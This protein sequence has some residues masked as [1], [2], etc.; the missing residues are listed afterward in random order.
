VSLAQNDKGNN[1]DIF[2]TDTST[3]SRE[4]Q[5]LSFE[6]IGLEKVQINFANP[7]HRSTYGIELLTCSGDFSEA[8]FLAKLEGDVLT[9]IEQGEKILVR[10]K[11]VHLN[12]EIEVNQTKEL[13][14]FKKT[15]LGIEDLAFELDGQWSIGEENSGKL[16][17]ETKDAAIKKLLSLLPG[18]IK[19]QLEEYGSS[20]EL[21]LSGLLNQDAKGNISFKAD[22]GVENGSLF[23]KEFGEGLQSI[24]LK[25]HVE[26]SPK[27]EVLKLEKFEA[28]LMED[29]VKGTLEIHGFD[30]PGIQL[31]LLG[32]FDLAN[33]Q[34][35]VDLKEYNDSK[36]KISADLQLKGKL[37]ELKDPTK[38]RSL[39]L[40]GKIKGE[41]LYLGNDS[42]SNQ[43]SDVNAFIEL[44]AS[45]CSIH[46]LDAIWNQQKFQIRG[47]AKNYLAYLFNDETLRI[48]GRL[49]A[50]KLHFLPP[51]TESSK[52]NDTAGFLLPDRILL[53]AEVEVGE[54]VFESF[55]ANNIQGRVLLNNE[56]L[57]LRH[58]QFESCQGK[59][60]MVGNWTK[61]ENGQQPV[62]V[63]ATLEK[64][65]IQE[66]FRQFENFG[67]Q[68]ITDKNLKG[69]LN[70]NIDLG[71]FFDAD[72]NF[73]PK[74]LYAFLDLRIDG[75]ELNHY[76]P[77]KAL[78]KYVRVEDLENVRFKTLENQIE[79][80]DEIIFIPSMEIQ[81]NAMN[82]HL[83]GQHS[84]SNEMNY[85]IKLQLKD[86]LAGPY[87]KDH[88]EAE[89][90]KEE[91]G[92]SVFVRMSGTPDKLSIRYDSKKAR[93][94]FK[95]EMKKEQKTVKEILKQEFGFD[96]EN[97]IKKDSNDEVPD[98]EDD[99]PE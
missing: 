77:L 44:K 92:V 76:E 26:Y 65:N 4:D 2:L 9:Q 29:L 15:F 69:R 61:R 33:L 87:I 51:K 6:H 78:S 3:S 40:D 53:E 16:R 72:F 81:N 83:E 94:N 62:V 11:L 70:G 58:L 22:F 71:F 5:P 55:Q 50:D 79:I 31:A 43:L 20:G 57:D 73:L 42:A 17:I 60:Q 74:T 34:R 45:E 12:S 28:R 13:L 98:W 63:N 82:L 41:H 39:F 24:R 23:L 66:L 47:E 19:N 32:E 18:D 36:G 80:R 95:Q 84:F 97:P 96:K 59:I 64:V 14:F 75:G 10:P 48:L 93:K 90:E 37:S 8:V 52:T 49:K 88:E 68:E 85:S 54:L 91:D 27:K 89:F 38:Y 1:F 25:G 67:Q 86:V 30:D 56:R 46:R 35:V 99:I 7:G 21:N